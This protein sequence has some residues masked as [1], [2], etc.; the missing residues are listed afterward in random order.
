MNSNSNSNKNIYMI[1][2]NSTVV[3]ADTIDSTNENV[4]DN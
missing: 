3:T 1:K 2:D 4:F